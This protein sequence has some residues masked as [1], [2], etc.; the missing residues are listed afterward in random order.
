VAY[1]RIEPDAVIVR[2]D[3][4]QRRIPADTV[5]V[6]AGQEPRRE[7]VDQLAAAGIPHVVIGGAADASGLDAG[8]AFREG[9]GAP[10]AVAR[11][12]AVDTGA[13]SGRLPQA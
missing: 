4:A 2:V 9:F 6:A 12:L 10:A 13:G 1:E 7:L 11:A 8:R 5:V 3:G